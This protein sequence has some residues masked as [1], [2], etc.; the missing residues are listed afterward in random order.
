MDV[1]KVLAVCSV[2]EG[3]VNLLTPAD[4]APAADHNSR[5]KNLILLFAAQ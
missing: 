3:K 5:L 1:Y 2:R 4:L